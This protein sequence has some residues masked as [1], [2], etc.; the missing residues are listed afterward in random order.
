MSKAVLLPI[1]FFFAFGQAFAAI[2]VPDAATMLENIKGQIPTLILMV[3]AIS[4]VMGF[5]F[6]IK[7]IMELKKFGEQRSMMSGEH[8]MTGPLVYLFVGALLIYLPTSI[9]TGMLTLF[10]SPSPLAWDTST[11]D[12]FASIKDAVFLIVQLVGVISFIR[13]LVILTHIGGGHGG[14]PGNFGKALAH[15][16]AGILCI[17]LNGFL[18]VIAGTLGITWS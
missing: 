3:T 13:G 14:Q 7:G 4:Y 10:A 6:V 5:F 9:H 18:Q 11:G 12:A 17:N 16:I 1:L 8:H 15:I 2:T